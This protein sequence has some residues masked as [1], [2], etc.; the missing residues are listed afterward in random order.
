MSRIPEQ[1]AS[2][3][4]ANA[5]MVSMLRNEMDDRLEEK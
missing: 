2:I 5:A 3:P 4:E 1:R